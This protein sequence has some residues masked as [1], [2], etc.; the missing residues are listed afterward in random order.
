MI[1]SYKIMLGDQSVGLAEVKREGLYYRFHCRCRLSGEVMY[2]I[3]ALCGEKEYDLGVCVP[4]ENGFGVDTKAPVK[5]LGEGMFSFYA[6]PRHSDIAGKFVPIRADEP[7]LYLE[8]LQ[9]AHLA[10]QNGVQG[11]IITDDD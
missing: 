11:I 4:V 5:K 2:H 6:V 8:K 9:G 1:E 3:K 10:F 7:F